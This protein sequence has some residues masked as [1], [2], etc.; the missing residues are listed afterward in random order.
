VKYDTSIELIS[1]TKHK[2]FLQLLDNNGEIVSSNLTTYLGC[3][4]FKVSNLSYTYQV[5]N[6]DTDWNR[7]DIPRSY[8]E[9]DGLN[10]KLTSSHRICATL[11]ATDGKGYPVEL[12]FLGSN[13]KIDNISLIIDKNKD[14]VCR[15]SGHESFYGPWE[16]GR[17]FVHASI[18]VFLELPPEKFDDLAGIINS[19]GA[20]E[21]VLSLEGVSGL[22]SENAIPEY[23]DTSKIK[24]LLAERKVNI[25]KDVDSKPHRLLS[26]KEFR[27][28]LKKAQQKMGDVQSKVAPPMNNWAKERVE[29]YVAVLSEDTNPKT[30][31]GDKG[32]LLNEDRAKRL[33]RTRLYTILNEMFNE[34]SNYAATNKLTLQELDDLSEDIWSF[35]LELKGAFDRGKW[36]DHDD[37]PEAVTD[38]CESEWQLWQYPETD[39]QDIKNGNIPYIDVLD[40][41]EAVISYL[42]LPVKSKKIDRMLVDALVTS[43]ISSFATEMLYTPQFG[44]TSSPLMKS[45]PL[46]QFLKDQAFS[47]SIIAFIPIMILFMAVELFEFSEDWALIIGLGFVGLWTLILL[48]GIFA[49]PKSW[50]LETRQKD[51][52][53]ELLVE[54]EL[55]RREIPVDAIV[56]ARHLQERLEKTSEKGAIWPS[57]VFPLLDDI[58]ARG[59]V[60]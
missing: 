28:Q 26:T 48:L 22:Y 52:T 54:M 38:R 35:S 9:S 47:F 59:G 4:D 51:K 25:P 18:D 19:G 49:L 20:D 14:A 5:K 15:L 11:A 21:A 34:A 12:K 36:G 13:E 23:Y 43:E 7:F 39:L 30:K 6:S 55:V 27:F 37:N 44:L 46:W 33:R 40:L 17:E 10:L 3:L 41:N 53:K 24:V 31:D 29:T 32:Y 57:A 56:S 45:H 60:L 2:W 50:A 42:A 16:L 58:I 8:P 1:E